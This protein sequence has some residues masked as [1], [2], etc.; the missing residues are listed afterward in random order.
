MSTEKTKRAK[1][2]H[3]KVNK[4]HFKFPSGAEMVINS[5]YSKGVFIA[6]REPFWGGE[7]K[8]TQKISTSGAKKFASKYGDSALFS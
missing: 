2:V 4:A 7:I 8:N 3:P 1:T 6:E 5:T